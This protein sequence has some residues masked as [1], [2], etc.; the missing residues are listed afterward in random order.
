MDVKCEFLIMML[1]CF[2]LMSL[3]NLK[4]TFKN[5]RFILQIN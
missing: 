5:E 4:L 3:Q 2:H 1:L